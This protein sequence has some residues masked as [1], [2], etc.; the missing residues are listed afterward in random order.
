MTYSVQNTDS[1]SRDVTF[2]WVHKNSGG[3][4]LNEIDLQEH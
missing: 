2:R 1:S 3:T 4:E